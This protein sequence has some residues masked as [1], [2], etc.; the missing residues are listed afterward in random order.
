MQTSRRQSTMH[1]SLAPCEKTKWG[2]AAR[3]Y[4]CV[5]PWHVLASAHASAIGLGQCY[6][7]ALP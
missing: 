1:V 4:A 5:Q 3:L 7:A 6:E 2:L